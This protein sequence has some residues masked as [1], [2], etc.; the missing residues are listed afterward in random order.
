MEDAWDLK[1]LYKEIMHQQFLEDA[2]KEV[3]SQELLLDQDDDIV[4][5]DHPRS[6]E[7]LRVESDKY[8]ELAKKLEKEKKVDSPE[9]VIK[10]LRMYAKTRKHGSL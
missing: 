10:F 7:M 6:N 3:K 1:R 5:D 2:G 9:N 4:H 8:L